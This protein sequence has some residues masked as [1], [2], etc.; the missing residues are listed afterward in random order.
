MAKRKRLPTLLA[1]AALFLLLLGAGYPE[2]VE[3]FTEETYTPARYKFLDVSPYTDEV[4][5][6]F[7][8]G[9]VYLFDGDGNFLRGYQFPGDSAAWCVLLRKDGTLDYYYN[10]SRK[11]RTYDREGNLLRVTE[12]TDNSREGDKLVQTNHVNSRLVEYGVKGNEF[13]K[14]YPWGER[15]VLRTVPNSSQE[16][17]GAVFILGV[18][19]LGYLG[20][21]ITKKKNGLPIDR[22]TPRSDYHAVERD[23]NLSRLAWGALLIV[24]LVGLMIVIPMLQE[25]L[26]PSPTPT[27]DPDFTV[28]LLAGERV[29]DWIAFVSVSGTDGTVAVC[30]QGGKVLLYDREGAYL[31]GYQLPKCSKYDSLLFR[32]DGALGYY[33]RNAGRYCV[34]DRAGTVL[35]EIP[36]EGDRRQSWLMDQM[37]DTDEA[38]NRYRACTWRVFRTPPSG[39]EEVFKDF[40]WA[41]G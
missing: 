4:L 12:H 14:E 1:L 26:K 34:F 8:N 30:M 2:K 16:A 28:S 41:R 36:V 39:E 17:L 6:G 13:W 22:K 11:I 19:I 33:D 21:W 10:R 32:P 7:D 3:V 38:G 27:S 15:V 5:L 24:I 9:K 23:S 40:S 35:E 20:Q 37:A 31:Q 18:F 29:D 25:K